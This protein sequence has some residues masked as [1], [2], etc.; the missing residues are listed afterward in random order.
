MLVKR[1]LSGCPG[2]SGKSLRFLCAAGAAGYNWQSRALIR[3][4]KMSEMADIEARLEKLRAAI[5]DHAYRYYVL[6]D[7]IVSDAEYDSLWRELVQLESDHPE[8][9]TPDSPT[10]RVPGE[11]SERFRKVRHPAPILQSGQR[12]WA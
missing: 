8:L 7:P 12:L 5:R 2:L 4:R 11:P 9:V 1:M 10:Q 3:A 6:D